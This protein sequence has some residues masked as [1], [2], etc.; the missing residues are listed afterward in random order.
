MISIGSACS[1]PW[2]AADIVASPSRCSRHRQRR[3]HTEFSRTD[4]TTTWGRSKHPA[5]C[6]GERALPL[7]AMFSF[8]GSGSGSGTASGSAS[9]G[10]EMPDRE[11]RT[12]I[13]SRMDNNG[14]G[15][16]SLAEVIS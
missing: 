15:M 2:T 7:G 10:L 9:S 5:S 8:G 11:Q 4:F 16:L 1:R 13:F 12:A 14:N 3:Q 6:R